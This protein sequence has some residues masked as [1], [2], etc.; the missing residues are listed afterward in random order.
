MDNSLNLL[1]TII[2]DGLRPWLDEN[3]VPDMFTTRLDTVS[4]V[5]PT[6]QSILEFEFYRPI[7]I[8]TQ[9]Y[10]KLITNACNDYCNKVIAQINED[11]NRN[12]QCFKLGD[13]LKKKLP[14]R[15]AEISKVIKER[16]YDIQHINPKTSS[17][18]I[19]QDHKIETYIFQLLKLA[20]VKMYLEIQAPFI[21]LLPEINLS[22]FIMDD[23]YI[24]LLKE[25]VPEKVFLKES[26]ASITIDAN[27]TKPNNRSKVLENENIGFKYI[28][29]PTNPNNL[30]DLHNSLIKNK[31]IHPDT[32]LALFKNVFS[33]KEIAEPIKWIGNPSEFFY[34]IKLIY[35]DHKL[36][37]DLKQKQ[38]DVA[39][40]CFVDEEG[41]T[42]DKDKVRKSKKPQA[43]ASKLE[44]AVN[45]LIV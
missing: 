39:F 2:Y 3:K 5:E 45:L 31:F 7:D 34:F 40:R 42:F 29:F 36:M 35:T 32:E 21:G 18:D 11:D 41:N 27:D 20:F 17:F 25:P 13:T 15:L 10:Q 4:L 14:K 43:T 23:V 38:W 16:Q 22:V 8:K 24:R 30:N 9:Y 44:K 26:M 1:D 12:L 33:G 37:G 6:F 19:D 28:H